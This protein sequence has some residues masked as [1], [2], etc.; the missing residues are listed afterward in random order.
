MSQVNNKPLSPPVAAPSMTE[1]QL[2]EFELKKLELEK[3]R[4]AEEDRLEQLQQL[5]G[6]KLQQLASLKEAQARTDAKQD[7]CPHTDEWGRARTVGNRASGLQK[8]VVVC[9]RCQKRWWDSGDGVPKA[10]TGRDQGQ[11][12]SYHLRPTSEK[13]GGMVSA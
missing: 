1:M 8:M 2:L 12:L 5:Q 6:L 11:A 10:E 13:I 7:S 9:Q 3:A 4:R